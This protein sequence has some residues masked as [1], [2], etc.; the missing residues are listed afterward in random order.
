[1]KMSAACLFRGQVIKVTDELSVIPCR[2]NSDVHE[3]RNDWGT[4]SGSSP[5]KMQ[6]G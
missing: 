5:V 4:V 3:W 6:W 2:V 1:M